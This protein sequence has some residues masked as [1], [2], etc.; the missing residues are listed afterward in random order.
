MK[1]AL[2]ARVSTPEQLEGY[3]IE[4]QKRAFKLLC[5]GRGWEPVAEYIEEGK[6]ARTDKLSKRPVFQ[7]ALA[8][9]QAH[10]YDVLVV[11]KLDRFSRNQRITENSLHA[12]GQ[13]GVAFASI[14]EQI[15]YT[16]PSGRLFLTLLGG[17]AQFYSDNLSQETKKGK[18][19]RKAQG[20]YNG[21]LPFGVMKGP[22]GIPKPHDEIWYIKDKKGE[23]IQ[24]RQPTYEGLKLAFE[25]AA[26]GETPKSIAQVLNARGYRTWG[27]H[28]QN[29]FSKDTIGGM[30]QNCFYIGKLPD[31]KGGWVKGKHSPIIPLELFEA[32][33]Q[34]RGRRRTIPQTIPAKG[35]KHSLSGIARCALCGSRLRVGYSYN[36][37]LQCSK[38]IDFGDCK[39]K[40][41]ILSTL[42]S[43]M[44][45]YLQTFK[46]PEDYK[47]KMLV[48]CR[49]IDNDIG[50]ETEINSIKGE[51]N[52]IKNLYRIG[53]MEY[54]QYLAERQQ[55]Q[56]RLAR[57]TVTQSKPDYLGRMAQ[58]LNS[59]GSA[60]EAADEEDR[61]RLAT[62]LFEA[63]WVKDS[64]VLGVT[65]RPEFV[66]F[67]DL[68]YPGCQ[69]KLLSG[70]PDG[71]RT[72]DLLR[73]RQ[74]C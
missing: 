36:T 2:Y 27:T 13:A 39:A 38:R 8:D 35:H 55:L 73:D 25:L 33:Q 68:A 15:D 41:A 46:L 53:D 18:N 7:K 49:G 5:Q 45:A 26:R 48:Y 51:L 34:A 64:L 23:I 4:A 12:L 62:E 67:F 30:L 24:E 63:V 9:A 29:P 70:D 65:P 17:L 47:G 44:A 60:W 71:I 43:Q 57:L 21:I 16:T 59:M 1:A 58:F 72:H 28:G 61:N 50:V 6:S 56:A 54:A 52:R 74:I 42:E 10:V 69:T 19:E 40:S 3:S 37:R 20:L 11:H 14:T 32:A 66:P 31:G 22:D